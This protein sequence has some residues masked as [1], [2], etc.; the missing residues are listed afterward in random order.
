MNR[1]K[2]NT[3]AL[4][5]GEGVWAGSDRDG[6]SRLCIVGGGTPCEG[7]ALE[8]SHSGDSGCQFSLLGAKLRSTGCTE[9]V[10]RCIVGVAD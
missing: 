6:W 7:L 1:L 10:G 5:V 4:P 3:A 8:L 9:H 2:N